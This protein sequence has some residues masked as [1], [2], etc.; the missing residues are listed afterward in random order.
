MSNNFFHT[1]RC[2]VL[3]C[4]FTN[5]TF[6]VAG[7]KHLFIMILQLSVEGNKTSDLILNRMAIKPTKEE[8]QYIKVR[9]DYYSYQ[10]D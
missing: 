8:L 9:Y 4:E 5:N 3:P 2:L 10:E 7:D 1:D 6:T